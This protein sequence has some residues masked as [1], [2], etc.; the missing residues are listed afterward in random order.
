MTA[1]SPSHNDAVHADAVAW[2]R[3]D[4]EEGGGGIRAAL[5]QTSGDGE[6][7]AFCFGRIDLRDPSIRNAENPR[8][9]A[10]SALAGALLRAADPPPPLALA[11]ADELPDSMSGGSLP[12]TRRVSRAELDNAEPFDRAAIALTEAF[13]DPSVQALSS[14]PGLMSVTSLTALP[15]SLASPAGVPS[16]DSSAPNADPRGLTLAER[17]WRALAAPLKDARPGWDVRLDWAEDLMPFQVEGVNAL[18][19]SERLLLADDMGLGKTLQ[20]IA[21]ARILKAQRKIASCLVVAPSSLL[22]QWR[23]EIEKWAP[24][25]SAIIIRGS[26]SDRATWWKARPGGPQPPHRPN[27]Q[28]ER[29]QVLLRRH[30]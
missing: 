24:E 30:H 10:L 11:L 25:L 8:N 13:A 21:A 1:P 14:Q 2:L 26:L 7:V 20:T 29:D 15:E 18:V 22:D 4:E 5:F 6:P 16:A 28:G 3:F 17:L 23:R 19:S 12:P 27:G 9:A